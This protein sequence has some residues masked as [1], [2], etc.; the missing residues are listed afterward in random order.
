MT[1]EDCHL[2][3]DGAGLAQEQRRVWR[4]RPRLSASLRSAT[5][6][7]PIGLGTGSALQAGRI[8]TGWSQTTA[9]L[10]PIS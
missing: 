6:R 9:L 4:G 5:M 7:S 1:N 10:D 2:A 8:L 3:L